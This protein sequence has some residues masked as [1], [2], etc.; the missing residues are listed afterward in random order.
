M[1]RYVLF[2]L[3]AGSVVGQV[4]LRQEVVSGG[5]R[6]RL[7]P[8]EKLPLSDPDYIAA[9]GVWVYVLSSNM[10]SGTSDVSITV[11]LRDGRVISRTRSIATRLFKWSR[12][13]FP[14]GMVDSV[15]AVS[16]KEV[17]DPTITDF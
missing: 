5:I 14:V 17:P 8:Q 13:Y 11:K 16:V 9:D 1:L 12:V 6:I 2:F 10:N 4:P 3:L 7:E 15:P